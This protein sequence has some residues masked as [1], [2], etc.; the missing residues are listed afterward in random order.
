MRRD[1]RI[2]VQAE[3]TM[4]SDGKGARKHSSRHGKIVL[5][6]TPDSGADNSSTR[7]IVAVISLGVLG[8]YI[9]SCRQA[10][11]GRKRKMAETDDQ[12]SPTFIS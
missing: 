8:E 7:H 6:R 2:F 4:K 12:P 10:T 5:C 3:V 11:D 9:A 1:L